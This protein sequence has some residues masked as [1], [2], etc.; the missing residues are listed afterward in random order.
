MG[1]PKSVDRS[2]ALRQVRN[3]N[4]VYVRLALTE[5]RPGHYVLRSLV[6]DVV[7]QRWI[8]TR[9]RLEYSGTL[10]ALN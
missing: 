1:S 7:P 2:E 5:D 3:A 9:H 4:R 10:V 6:A 8:D